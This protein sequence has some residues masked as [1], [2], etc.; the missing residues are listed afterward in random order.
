MLVHI[1]ENISLLKKDIIVILDKK[2]VESSKDTSN[3]ILNLIK[4]DALVNPITKNTKT[5]IV[6]R[7]FKNNEYKYRLYASNISSSSLIKRNIA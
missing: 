4:K 6:T 1:G 3:F 5:Y 2:T 7:E